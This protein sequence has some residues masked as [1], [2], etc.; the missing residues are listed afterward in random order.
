MVK[1][2]SNSGFVYIW[3]DKKRKRY[4]VGSHWGFEDD[5]YICS[6]N[7]MLINYKKHPEYFKRRIL[8]KVYT[9]RKDLYLAEEFWL[10]L[11]KKEELGKRYYNFKNKLE[12]TWYR[13]EKE[14]KSISEKISQTVTE[15]YNDPEFKEK[16]MKGRE[17]VSKKLKGKKRDPEV[18]ARIKATK[19]K[20]FQEKR[21]QG[22][23]A[24][25]GQAAENMRLSGLKRRGRIVTQKEKDNL[26]IAMDKVRYTDEYKFKV[27]EGLKRSYRLKKEALNAN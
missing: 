19:Q 3:F 24:F 16:Y 25:E 8:T 13:D 22:L 6:S 7:W 4:Y 5:G 27:S 21:D 1:K 11:I 14:I 18:I 26:K 10:G 17:E 20:Q 2:K 23:P 12:R 9:N 15:L